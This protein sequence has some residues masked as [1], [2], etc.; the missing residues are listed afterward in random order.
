MAVLKFQVPSRSADLLAKN[1]R[2]LAGNGGYTVQ[3]RLRSLEISRRTLR[4]SAEPA[5]SSCIR[6]P[7]WGFQACEALLIENPTPTPPHTGEKICSQIC[8]PEE[9]PG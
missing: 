9:S 2:I 1:A 7:L 6:R 5:I 8:V 4:F 3:L